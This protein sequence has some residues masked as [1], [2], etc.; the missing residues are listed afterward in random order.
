MSTFLEWGRGEV[1][2]GLFFIVE[3]RLV[4]FGESD[5]NYDREAFPCLSPWS[6]REGR[7]RMGLFFI[8][9]LHLI[10]FGESDFNC[11]REAFPC[12]PS[13]SGGEGG[14]EDGLVLHH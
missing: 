9:E 3:L 14:V 10:L 2:D 13:W 5:F 6:G 4:L 1:E 11:D 7:L 12:P 8:V